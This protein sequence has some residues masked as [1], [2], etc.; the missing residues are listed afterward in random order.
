MLKACPSCGKEIPRSNVRCGYCDQPQPVKSLPPALVTP[1]HPPPAKRASPGRVLAPAGLLGFGLGYSA[2][3]A[4]GV[5][6]QV[7]WLIFMAGIVLTPVLAFLATLRK[8]SSRQAWLCALSIVC[9]S[10]GCVPGWTVGMSPWQKRQQERFAPVISAIEDYRRKNGHY[11][12]RDAEAGI[13]ELIPYLKSVHLD[14]VET[15][16]YWYHNRGNSNSFSIF[17][18][19]P[20]SPAGP[21][22]YDP[23]TKTWDWLD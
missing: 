5:S 17:A 21:Y 8:R 7:F 16:P 13:D 15:G 20:G 14:G 11:P 18:H 9:L 6:I 3:Y 22:V 12:R 19:Y 23:R 10:G 1:A 4:D 2:G